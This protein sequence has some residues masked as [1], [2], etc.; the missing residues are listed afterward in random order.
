MGNS[1]QEPMATQEILIG[2]TDAV[3]ALKG[4]QH[5]LL[6][7][8]NAPRAARDHVLKPLA[9]LVSSLGEP[10]AARP[11]HCPEE[12][13][14]QWQELVAGQRRTLDLRA[15]RFLSWHAETATSPEFHDYLNREKWELR[16]SHLQGLVRCCHMKWSSTFRA[17]PVVCRVRQRVLQYSGPSRLL[18]KWQE[19]LRMLLGPSGDEEFGRLLL[20]ENTDIKPVCTAWHIEESSAYAGEAV[21]HAGSQCLSEL[22]RVPAVRQFLMKILLPWPH[23]AP[24]AFRDLVRRAILCPAVVRGA[25]A[26]RDPLVEFVLND[27]RLGD[28]RLPANRKN[29]AGLD[30]AAR[31]LIEWLSFEDIVFFFEHVLPK[32]SDPHGR[33]E[34]WLRYRS[35][36]KMSRP[37]LY[38]GDEGRVQTVVRESRGKIHYGTLGGST[39]AFLLDFGRIVVVEFSKVG[40]ACYIYEQE[41]M[42]RVLKDLWAPHVTHEGYLKDR[43]LGKKINHYP[44][45]QDVVRNLLAEFGIRS[46]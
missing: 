18:N 41:A 35:R 39:S 12:Y 14:R 31:Q 11:I 46:T 13:I 8:I 38:W 4:A 26:I 6:E 25:K 2:L 22:D 15:V 24:D 30:D 28:P 34:F 44:G 40:N 33:K 43:Q 10:R 16:A 9:D 1:N 36:L 45:W 19:A 23:W 29:W 17:S 27:K 5:S 42:E 21:R 7:E 37:L 3:K 20:Q 32:R